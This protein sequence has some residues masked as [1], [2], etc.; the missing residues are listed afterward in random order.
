MNRYDLIGQPFMET[1][2]TILCQKN[3]R[4]HHH[5]HHLFTTEQFTLSEIQTSKCIY[6][7]VYRTPI[8]IHVGFE[9]I[10]SIV[11]F[12]IAVTFKGLRWI[13]W[14]HQLFI[15]KNISYFVWKWSP[16]T[17]TKFAEFAWQLFVGGGGGG[18]R[19]N[20]RSSPTWAMVTD[21]GD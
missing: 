15:N 17:K 5:H 4:H 16:F 9:A 10:A 14:I 20:R 2:M 3:R 8:Q 6:K 1:M 19:G 21:G 18:G 13:L 11:S 7:L 12:W